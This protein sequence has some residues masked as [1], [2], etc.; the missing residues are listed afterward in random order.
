MSLLFE[1]VLA[2]SNGKGSSMN[3]HGL[4]LAA[5]RV[6]LMNNQRGNESRAVQTVVPGYL[7]SSS[8]PSSCGTVCKSYC[9]SKNT[10]WT[11][12]RKPKGMVS[13]VNFP[14]PP[15][16]PTSK[17]R[18]IWQHSGLSSRAPST[19]STMR[20]RRAAWSLGPRK[21]RRDGAELLGFSR[22][23]RSHQLK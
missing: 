22:T 3:S 23:T 5:F 4:A 12:K 21:R 6:V 1:D 8:P 14:R 20:K 7:C 19:M 13:S 18:V 17:N 11:L 9:R 15:N 10:L 2:L 16:G